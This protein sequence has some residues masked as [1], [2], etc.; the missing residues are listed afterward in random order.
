[1]LLTGHT[2]L[3][4]QYWFSSH[5][6]WKCIVYP[7]S[8]TFP[9]ILPGLSLYAAAALLC[10]CQDCK[11][12][13]QPV[14]LCMFKAICKYNENSCSLLPIL[15]CCLRFSFDQ[16]AN[17]SGNSRSTNW[18]HL[19]K[20]QFQIWIDYYGFR[21][22]GFCRFA[23]PRPAQTIQRCPGHTKGS[24]Q[25]VLISALVRYPCVK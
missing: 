20:P 22:I 23:I 3:Y 1:M 18:G 7:V 19:K 11:A 16:A 12:D 25:Y 8:F 14:I 4:W 2:M 15:W 21:R 17:C 6:Y 9:F 24:R 13:Q 5:S 10:R